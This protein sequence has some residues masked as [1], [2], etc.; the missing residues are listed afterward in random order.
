MN[1]DI[2]EGGVVKLAELKNDLSIKSLRINGNKIGQNV[3]FVLYQYE[4][5][6]IW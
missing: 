4:K 3:S 5:L 1:N 6:L 2:G